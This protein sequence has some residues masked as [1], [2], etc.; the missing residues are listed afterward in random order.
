MANRYVLRNVL[1]GTGKKSVRTAEL[2]ERPGGSY[3]LAAD[4]TVSAGAGQQSAGAANGNNG[5]N[6]VG[7]VDVPASNPLS[8]ALQNL[9]AQYNSTP[10]YQPKTADQI[11]AQAQGEYKSYYD[12]MRLSARQNQ[13]F[14]DLML[15]QQRNSLN[16][17]YDRQREASAQQ[18]ADAYSRA[19]RQMLGRGMQRSSYTAQTLSNIDLAG[20]K[21]QQDIWNQQVESEGNIDA[22]RTLLARQL[23]DQLTQY[24]ASEQS[25]ILSR[26]RSLE[27]QEYQ[28]GLT[29][30]QYKNSL[31]TQIYQFLYQNSRDAVSDS[32]FKEKMDYQ[33]ERDAVADKQWQATFNENVRQFNV[34]QAEDGKSGGGGYSGGGGTKTGNNAGNNTGNNTPPTN[35]N[36]N[37]NDVLSFDAFIAALG[38]TNNTNNGTPNNTKKNPP[39]YKMNGAPFIRNSEKQ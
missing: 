30:A 24:D 27:D 37:G 19:D 6:G 28:R 22:Q 9:I 33:R 2:P 10:L 11:R 18:Y 13:E 26:I 1:Y 17:S 12:Q 16:R 35:N 36:T 14:T 8:D 20:A 7:G 25:D 29:S 23:A 34:K 5:V 31:S 39:I 21:A 4:G 32:Q 15:Q 38:G 3:G